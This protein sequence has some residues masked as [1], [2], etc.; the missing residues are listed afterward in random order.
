MDGYRGKHDDLRGLLITLFM[1]LGPWIAIAV[2][3]LLRR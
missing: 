1:V 2:V 3:M